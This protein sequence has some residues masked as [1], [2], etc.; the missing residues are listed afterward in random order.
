MN[1]NMTMDASSADGINIKS[2]DIKE[3]DKYTDRI[4]HDPVMLR[5]ALERIMFCDGSASAS[6]LGYYL[7]DTQGYCSCF[8][9]LGY[10]LYETIG[11]E[12]RENPEVL[13]VAIQTGLMCGAVRTHLGCALDVWENWNC[14]RNGILRLFRDP[15][16]SVFIE[17][18]DRFL[19]EILSDIEDEDVWYNAV[20]QA[21]KMLRKS[22]F[23]G[24]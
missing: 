7:D 10:P 21:Q 24:Y 11:H 19:I 17:Y 9:P 3:M 2:L 14:M 23:R 13:S 18:Q 12:M 8:C 5:A 22:E 4:I 15:C 16:L 20:E 1:I 6:I